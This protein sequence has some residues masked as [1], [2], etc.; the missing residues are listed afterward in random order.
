[1][2]KSSSDIVTAIIKPENTPGLI[3]GQ[4]TLKM[5]IEVMRQV[6]CGLI[7]VF[8]GLLELWKHIEYHIKGY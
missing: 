8:V 7:G 5:H 3:S 6:K 1:M 2:E 4:V